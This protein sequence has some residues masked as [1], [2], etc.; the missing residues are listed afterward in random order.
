M[1]LISLGEVGVVV[2]ERDAADLAAELEAA[3][4]AGEAAE[5]GPDGVERHAELDGQRGGAGGVAG[6][7]PPRG[8]QLDLAQPLAPADKVEAAAEPVGAGPERPVVLDAVVG[9]GRRRRR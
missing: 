2:D 9:A 1:A 3:G 6:V 4:D 5:G 8:R 7:V